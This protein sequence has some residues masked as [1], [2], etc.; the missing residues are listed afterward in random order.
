M[1]TVKNRFICMLAII[2]IISTYITAPVYASADVPKVGEIK[3][4]FEVT[5]STCTTYP[6]S[7][8][9]EKQLFR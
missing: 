3:N 4:G 6:I 1:Y 7:S 9:S 8:L 5:S 2:S